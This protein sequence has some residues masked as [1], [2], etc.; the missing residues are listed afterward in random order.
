MAVERIERETGEA[1]KAA[2]YAGISPFSSTAVAAWVSLY[3]KA[4]RCFPRYHHFF[5]T[6]LPQD[7]I[8]HPQ[9]SRPFPRMNWPR[10]RSC[11]LPLEKVNHTIG[12][13]YCE[14]V[15]HYFSPPPSLPGTIRLISARMSGL[16]LKLSLIR[17]F[18]S[19]FGSMFRKACSF[20]F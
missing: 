14:S 3:F 19:I 15:P 8:S 11:D 20:D 18:A 1:D 4:P 5:L 7:F 12:L 13:A 17:I 9:V 16:P 6:F 10:Q 2:K